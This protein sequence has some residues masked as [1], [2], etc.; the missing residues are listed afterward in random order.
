MTTRVPRRE[1][2][3]LLETHPLRSR[4]L[5][6]VGAAGELTP[7]ALAGLTGQRLGT[8]AYHVRT[9]ASAGAL[10]LAREERVR[11]AVAHYY[12]VTV[13]GQ[14]A[15][16]STRRSRSPSPPSSAS[17][18]TSSSASTA[19]PARAP[20]SPSS[21]SAADPSPSPQASRPRRR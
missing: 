7:V 4:I 5:E 15:R 19:S 17:S 20:R 2:G 14:A 13:G 9:L 21:A 3:E 8:V 18:R 12:R 1:L 10:E 11:G 6:L 16:T